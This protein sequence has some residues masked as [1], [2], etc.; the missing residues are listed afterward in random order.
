[1]ANDPIP[2]DYFQPI[3]KYSFYEADDWNVRVIVELKGVGKLPKESFVSRFLER[4]FDLKIFN[5]Q[6]KNW[7]FGVGKT[8][9]KIDPNGNIVSST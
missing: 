1:V 6:G 9:N 5:Y 8:H 3:T 7:V 4:S 2:Q